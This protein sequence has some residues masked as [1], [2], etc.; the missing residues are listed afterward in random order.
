MI[1]NYDK[2][3]SRNTE[4]VV[5]FPISNS[6]HSKRLEN[7]KDYTLK[8]TDAKPETVPFSILLDVKLRAVNQ[9]GIEGSLARPATYIVD[10]NADVRFAYVGKMLEIVRPSRPSLVSS[11]I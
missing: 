11:T 3:R 1:S 10:K 9:L 4:V 6:E 7:F 5:A 8:I 2:F